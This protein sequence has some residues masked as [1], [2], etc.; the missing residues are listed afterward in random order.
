MF[1]FDNH[2]ITFKM[3]FPTTAPGPITHGSQTVLSERRK[4]ANLTRRSLLT[5][6]LNT[7]SSGSL[8]P[9]ANTKYQ[10]QFKSPRVSNLKDFSK[11]SWNTNT[12]LVY[13]PSV[14]EAVRCK[15]ESLTFPTMRLFLSMIFFHLIYWN[16]T[17]GTFI[18]QN[19][20]AVTALVNSCG[21]R[22]S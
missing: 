11:S 4:Q 13:T 9:V 17:F 19:I 20:A 10:Q 18:R 7:N 15:R 1:R 22:A 3:D 14:S 21:N 2:R 5:R 8:I 6:P 12:Q 16:G